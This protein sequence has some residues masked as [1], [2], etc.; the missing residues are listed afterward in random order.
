MDY[1]TIER[2]KQ[3]MRIDQSTDDAL[4]ALLIT[5]AS[6]ALDRRCTG[7]NDEEATN[8]FMLESKVDEQAYGL[9]NRDGYIV[10][11]PHKPTI[12]SVEAFSYRENITRPWFT[13][14]IDRCEIMSNKITAYPTNLSWDYPNRCTVKVSYT[15]GYSGSTAALPADLI[16]ICTVL[17][18]RFYREYEGGLADVMGLAEIGQMV[19]TKAWPSRVVDQLDTFIRREGWN[20]PG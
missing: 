5:S 19:Y 13:V 4:L 15:G 11:R 2:V 17:S 8:Y 10:C 1:T 6:R 7:V 16:E 20:Y 9:I 18:A 12:N 14:G 3:S